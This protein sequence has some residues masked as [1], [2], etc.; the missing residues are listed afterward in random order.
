MSPAPVRITGVAVP[1][2]TGRVAAMEVVVMVVAGRV[3]ASS[4]D[5]KQHG[6]L[7]MPLRP[8]RSQIK[9]GRQF[10]ILEK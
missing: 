4:E 3:V 5:I 2:V 6:Y 7:E 9:A 1:M 8:C 10:Q